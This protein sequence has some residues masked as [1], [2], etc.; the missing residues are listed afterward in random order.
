MQKN[1]IVNKPSLIILNQQK[2]NYGDKR[3]QCLQ[4][5]PE[6]KASGFFVRKFTKL[7]LIMERKWNSCGTEREFSR[8]YDRPRSKLK[9][10][11][12]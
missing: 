7:F 3:R 9:H 10:I 1:I 11:E 8:I 12:M 4:S 5:D 6:A 2:K